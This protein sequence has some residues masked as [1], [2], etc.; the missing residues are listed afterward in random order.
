M[1]AGHLFLW[2]SFA[3]AVQLGFEALA[4]HAFRA[5]RRRPL[6]VFFTAR[7][8]D[9]HGEAGLTS[10]R[11]AT[12]TDAELCY[13]LP[14]S[15]YHMQVSRRVVVSCIAGLDLWLNITSCDEDDY[16]VER[17]AHN[18][19]NDELRK[20]ECNTDRRKPEWRG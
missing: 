4:T 8:A 5:N 6:T 2:L 19:G 20:G 3:F 17:A 15:I 12:A 14:S 11:S 13:E 7:L 9:S 1:R 10:I 18:R 16:D